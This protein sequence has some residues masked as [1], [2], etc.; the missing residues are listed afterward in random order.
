M[1]AAL[2]IYGSLE[3]VSGGYLYDRLLVE[4][5][6]Q[7][8]HHVD[9]ISLPW[10]SYAG[11]L[12][13]NITQRFDIGDYDLILQDELNH[14]SLFASNRRLK[15]QHPEVPI[16]A[17]VHHLRV[18]ERHPAWLVPVY[19]AVERAYLRTVNF[20]IFN[21][22]TT[23]DAVQQYTGPAEHIIGYPAG[24]R[25]PLNVTAKQVAQRSTEASLGLLFVGNVIQRKGLHTVIE[26][27]AKLPFSSWHLSIVA[28]PKSDE[29]YLTRLRQRISTHGLAKHIRWHHHPSD[30]ELVT[31]YSTHH[32][33]VMPS[34]YEG[35]GIVYLEA[36][37]A[38]LAVLG[39]EAGAAEEFITPGENGYLLN[40]GDAVGLAEHI[41]RLHQN[42]AGLA[43]L[44]VEALATYHAHPSWSSTMDALCDFLTDI[45]GVYG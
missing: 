1:R 26:A 11:R 2:I 19:E 18:S 44:G 8:G 21:S 27:T 12:L 42:R 33:F 10:R 4:R 17:I 13:Q 23:R 43:C 6:R 3:T 32:V 15:R 36:M 39:S 30:D 40:P 38:G 41:T 35:F 5:L 34:E 7:R 14:P 20:F 28:G 31:L 22:C 9:V 16:V 45:G 29:A 25:L 37:G 24:D